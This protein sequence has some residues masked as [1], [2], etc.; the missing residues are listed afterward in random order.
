MRM[1]ITSPRI[2]L[3]GD[4]FCLTNGSYKT[5]NALTDRLN[6]VCAMAQGQFNLDAV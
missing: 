5:K 1:C 6:L 4:F 3:S 2:F